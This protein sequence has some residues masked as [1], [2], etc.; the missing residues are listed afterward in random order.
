[1]SEGEKEN[2]NQGYIVDL[3]SSLLEAPGECIC[4]CP[5]A[6]MPWPGAAQRIPNCPVPLDH[7][8][9]LMGQAVHVTHVMV[10]EKP[11]DRRGVKTCRG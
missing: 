2:P 6:P 4:L 1:M 5:A 3:V 7:A 8:R 10:S 9:L 11:W